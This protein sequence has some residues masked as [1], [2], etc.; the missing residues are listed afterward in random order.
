MGIEFTRP[1]YTNFENPPSCLLGVKILSDILTV[2]A[3]N[4]P[5]KRKYCFKDNGPT[6]APG[7]SPGRF[8]D[9]FEEVL[10]WE[11]FEVLS[12]FGMVL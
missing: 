10:F 7:G 8:S 3:K 1:L 6:R 2:R 4:L 11:F 5:V 12:G 9:G